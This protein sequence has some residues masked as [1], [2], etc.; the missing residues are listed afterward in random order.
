[1]TRPHLETISYRV[2]AAL[3]ANGNDPHRPEIRPG[4]MLH[5]LLT[6]D[7]PDLIAEVRRLRAAEDR[8]RR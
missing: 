1:M 2:A 3:A 5:T 6:E 8:A 7:V 4:G